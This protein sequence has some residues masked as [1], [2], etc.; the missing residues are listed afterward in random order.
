MNGLRD[1]RMVGNQHDEPRLGQ[2]LTSCDETHVAQIHEIVRSNGSNHR[3]TVREIAEE[4]NVSIG[5]CYD[6]LMTKL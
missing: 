3:L 1:L 5:S 4:C 2:P 6:I